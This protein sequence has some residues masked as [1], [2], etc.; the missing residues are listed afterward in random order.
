MKIYDGREEGA[1][2]AEGGAAGEP[3]ERL[4]VGVA[5]YAIADGST[6]LVTS[7]LGS[8]VAVGVTDGAAAAGMLH[9]MLP[10]AEDR[11]VQN[12]AKYADTGIPLLIEALADAGART[13][14]LVAKMAGGSEMISFASQARSIGDRNADAVERALE[15]A[16]VPLVGQDVGGEEGRTVEYTLDGAFRITTAR[17]DERTL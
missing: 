1:T 14:A 13:D 5:D 12:P 2:A 8:C 7:G 6:V 17:D 3:T 10:T 11:D 9:V 16:G 4:S 15:A